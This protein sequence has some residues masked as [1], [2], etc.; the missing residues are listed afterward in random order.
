MK[1]RPTP[2]TDNVYDVTVRVRDNGSTRLQD[3]RS[4][5][6][7][8]EDVNET[9]VISGDNSPD[10]EEIEFDVDTADLTSADYVIGTYMATDDEGDSVTWAVSGTDAGH[11]SI[12]MTTGELSFSIEPDFENPEDLA[13][14]D[15]QGA[16]D[17]M[18]KVVLEAEDDNA[19]G[20][21]TGTKTGTFPVTV[22]VTN[23]DET[24]EITTT[25]ASHTAPSFMEIEYDA[26]S[27]D[28]TVADYDARDEEGQTI[29][30][31]KTGTDAGDFTIDS[32]TGVLS[33][34]QRPDYEMPADTPGS[35]ET[36][37]DNEYNITV[38]A[39]DTASPANTR[40]LEV[41]VT[42]TDVNERPDINENFNPPQTYMEIEYDAT[43]T[44]PDVHT[45]TATDYDDMDTFEWS[46]LGTDAAH[47]DIDATTGVLTFRQDANFG[48]GPLPNFE[49]PRDDDAGDGSNTYSITVRATDDDATDQKSTDYPV[50]VTVTNVNEQP[51]FI[52]TPETALTPDE[53]DANTDYV[54]VDLADYDA[55]DEEGGVTWSLTGTDSGDFAISADGVVTFA[56][57][58]NHED[59]DDSDDDNVYNFTVVATDSGSNRRSVSTAVTATVQ[60]VEEAGTVTVDNLNPG[61]G[62]EVEFELTD[63]D[64]GI[65]LTLDSNGDPR[66]HW[67][68]QSQVTGESWGAVPGVV[69]P[70]STTLTYTVDEDDTDKALRATVTYID[71][72]GPGKTATSE[73][74]AAGSG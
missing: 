28:L 12:N 43:G 69:S 72:R 55:H 23:V 19:Q 61:V 27:A 18:Y 41:T 10:F 16:S 1:T 63:P 7:T 26:A 60:D 30:W 42:V 58:P 48:Q 25:A 22:T 31:S 74:T 56:Q 11:F 65:D 20:G 64:G 70:A 3:T 57:T 40:E 59:P 67:I 29:T 34:A 37:G 6:I 52:G 2:A 32:G 9:P 45:F 54:V 50:V 33:F 44:R 62:D 38:R 8:V 66:I 73:A 49:H 36:E 14:S 47:L 68:V 53:N 71:R 13:D 5:A 39:T 15:S 21:K 35:G 51:S 46:L 24:P 17:N 4:V